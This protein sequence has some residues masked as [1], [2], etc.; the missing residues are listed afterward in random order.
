MADDTLRIVGDLQRRISALETREFLNG[1]RARH[2]FGG[3][4]TLTTLT[5]VLT[6]DT[7]AAGTI[8]YTPFNGDQVP[9]FD[10]TGFVVRTFAELTLTLNN[11]NHVAAN[12]YDIFVFDN[13]GTVTLGSGVAWAT[14]TTRGVGAG[15]TQLARINGILTNAVAIVLRNGANTYNV[16]VNRATYLGTFYTTATAQTEMRFNGGVTAGAPASLCL[17]NQYNGTRAAFR[18]ADNTDSV[19]SG[20]ANWRSWMNNALNRVRFVI[21]EQNDSVFLNFNFSSRIANN[22]FSLPGIG[23]DA[24]NALAADCYNSWHYISG[25]EAGVSIHGNGVA[26]YSGMPGLGYHF[27]QL[28]EYSTAM[29]I[30]GDAGLPLVSRSGAT[31]HMIC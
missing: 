27:L 2:P 14:A 6:A 8:Y 13:A 9:I 11:P 3:R 10:G 25:V 31:G 30:F 26:H 17:Y 29:F 18:I 22:Q 15:T 7:L 16:A 23:L 20:G 28:L 1:E 21:G 5:P 24:I 4:L 19:A 12:I